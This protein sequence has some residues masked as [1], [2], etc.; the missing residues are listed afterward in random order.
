VVAIA[1]AILA[2]LCVPGASAQSRPPSDDQDLQEGLKGVER[3]LVDLRVAVGEL[4]GKHE[5]T[6]RLIDAMTKR[7]DSLQALMTWAFGFLT[8]P[9]AAAIWGVIS[10]STLKLELRLVKLEIAGLTTESAARDG[11]LKSLYERLGERY[12]RPGD[13][14]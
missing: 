14:M 10:L 9:A 3:Q 6:L 12:P 7:I 13:A 2:F 11:L 5:S 1:V 4:A 8:I